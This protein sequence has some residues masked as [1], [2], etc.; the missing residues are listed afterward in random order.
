MTR[1]TSPLLVALAA[2][3]LLVL[4]TPGRRPV[5]VWNATASV[6]LGLYRLRPLADGGPAPGAYLLVRPDAAQARLY[7]D[8]GYLPLGVPLLK[9]VA[10]VAGQQVCGRA[11]WM[12]VDG[13]PLARALAA[14]GQGRPL[15]AWRGCRRLLPG[16]V[17]LLNPDRADALDGRYFGPT[18]LTAVL[19]Q[20][21]PLWVRP[22]P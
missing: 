8:R 16:E 4:A 17:L 9:P 2:V 14:D 19:G 12:L 13:R 1:R 10:A 11:G 6:P 21:I 3:L 7:A 20:A 18:P 22:G 5:L 15:T